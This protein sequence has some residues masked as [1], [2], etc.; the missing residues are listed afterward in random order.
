M[1]SMFHVRLEPLL[2]ADSVCARARMCAHMLQS[3][4]PALGK[5]QT[6]RGSSISIRG[7]L[8]SSTPAAHYS[9]LGIY[10]IVSSNS[11][12]GCTPALLPCNSGSPHAEL[13]GRAGWGGGC[14]AG[15]KLAEEDL[16]FSCVLG[17]KAMRLFI[18]FQV[19]SYYIFKHLKD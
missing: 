14:A 10:E 13:G 5:H 1:T 3:A 2:C 6:V 17:L 12:A 15:R 4:A 9:P 8:H 7:Q 18:V 19:L 16:F 11:W